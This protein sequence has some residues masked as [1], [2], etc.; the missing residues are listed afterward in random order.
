MDMYQ[1]QF[2]GNWKGINR[3]YCTAES[4]K[5]IKRPEGVEAGGG[6]KKVA[7]GNGVISL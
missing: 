5:K 6:T 4:D 3:S 7:W 1:V 2:F